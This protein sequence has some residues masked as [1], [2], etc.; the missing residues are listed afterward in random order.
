M[1]KHLWVVEMLSDRNGKWEP[2]VGAALTRP[3]ASV[4]RRVWLSRNP[5]DKFRIR[6]Y[7]KSEK[8]RP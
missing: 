6:K 4:E 1:R 3:D 7:V 2:T 5:T 8:E